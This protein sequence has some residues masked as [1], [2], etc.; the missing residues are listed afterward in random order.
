[1]RVNSIVIAYSPHGFHDQA[2][3]AT[4]ITSAEFDRGY[5]YVSEVGGLQGLFILDR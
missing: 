3:P 5:G 2:K 1:M 4:S